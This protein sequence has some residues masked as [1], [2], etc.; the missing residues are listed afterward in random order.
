VF[1]VNLE[2]NHVL[3][4]LNFD[5]DLI[6]NKE[7]GPRVDAVEHEEIE[8]SQTHNLFEA[9]PVCGKKRE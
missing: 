4:K 2:V 9:A 1:D 3:R 7:D 6:F 5:S 8:Y